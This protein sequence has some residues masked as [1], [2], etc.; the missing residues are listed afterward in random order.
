MAVHRQA[1][2]QRSTEMEKKTRR[3][4]KQTMSLEERLSGEAQR[5]R[6]QAQGT[7]HGIQRERLIR[8]ARQLDTAS[9]LS[10]WISPTNVRPPT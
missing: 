1:P 4:F 2:I 3:R 6:K 5:L 9:Q 7:P 8:R 10:Q